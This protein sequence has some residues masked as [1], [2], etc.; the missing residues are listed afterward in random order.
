MP[1]PPMASVPMPMGVNV[2]TATVPDRA[3]IL[4]LVAAAFSDD[5]HD[6]QQEVDIVVDTWTLEATT[7][8][9]ELVAV[10]GGAVVGHVMAAW[11]ALGGRP[12]AAVAPLAV[13]PTHHGQGIGTALMTELVSR[14]ESEELPLVVLLGSPAYYGRFGFEPAGP[15]GIIYRPVGAGNPDF[16]V[17]RFPNYDPLYRGDFTY[18]WEQ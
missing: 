8:E 7:P 18:C 11:G 13:A 12:V 10:N 2:H 15:L 1:G 9:L 5:G 14:V 4:K 16:Q 6:G 17:R 3:S